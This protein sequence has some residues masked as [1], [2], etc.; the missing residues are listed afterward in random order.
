[1]TTAIQARLKQI[2]INTAGQLLRHAVNS[3]LAVYA[4]DSGLEQC[5]QRGEADRQRV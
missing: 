1:M 5:V 3:F 4:R 2:Q